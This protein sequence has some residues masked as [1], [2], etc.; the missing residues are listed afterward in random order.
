LTFKKDDLSTRE[1]A[2]LM[3]AGLMIDFAWFEFKPKVQR[4][5]GIQLN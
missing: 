5:G 1:K 3:G 2:L 4:R